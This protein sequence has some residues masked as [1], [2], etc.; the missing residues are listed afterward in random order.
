MP[1]DR[2]DSVF[3]RWAVGVTKCEPD[4][5]SGSR[6][7]RIS[8]SGDRHLWQIS[9]TWGTRK[10]VWGKVSWVARGAGGPG[11]VSG[12]QQGPPTEAPAHT[13]W[14]GAPVALP[15]ASPRRSFLLD[16]D[17]DEV[18]LAPLLKPS[19]DRSAHS[20]PRDHAP[21]CALSN[22]SART[23]VAGVWAA[24]RHPCCTFWSKNHRSNGQPQERFYESRVAP[25]ARNMLYWV[26]NVN[27]VGLG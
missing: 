10:P 25:A 16:V 19:L 22:P 26:L 27:Y 1:S 17:R 9:K 24:H 5:V 15:A 8:L 13:V 12:A 11:D 2:G 20:T 6:T 3:L 23:R 7:F 4:R 14:P 18:V 21:H